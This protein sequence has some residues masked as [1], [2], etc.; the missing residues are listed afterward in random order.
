MTKYNKL[1]LC[2]PAARIETNLPTI[3]SWG[4]IMEYKKEDGNCGVETP[5]TGRM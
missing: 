1:Q 3:F 5:L 4:H 2:R